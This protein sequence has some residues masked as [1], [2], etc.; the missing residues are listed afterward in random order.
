[1]DRARLTDGSFGSDRLDILTRVEMEERGD[2]FRGL[3][4][5]LL[6]PHPDDYTDDDSPSPRLV[7]GSE[8]VQQHGYMVCI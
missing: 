3:I 5:P 8:Y 6:L 7:G 4:S 1:M 2:D